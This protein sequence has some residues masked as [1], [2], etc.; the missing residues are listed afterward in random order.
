MLQ[1]RLAPSLAGAA[2][3]LAL[4]H[5]QALAATISVGGGCSLID[6][7]TA[8]NTDTATG[9][10]SAGSGADMISLPASSTHTLTSVNNSTYGDTGLPVVTSTI[11]IEGNDSTITRDSSAPAFRIFAIASTGDLTLQETTVSG[12]LTAG[13]GGFASGSGGGVY[14]RGALT[15]TDSTISGNTA[16]YG[17]GGVLNFLSTATLS[18]STISGNSAGGSGGGVYNRG[19]LTLTDSTISGNSAGN[20]G[21]GVYNYNSST[22]TLSNSTISGNTAFAGGGVSNGSSTVTVSDSTLSG[23]TA[24]FGGGVCNIYGTV[25]LSNSTISGNSAGSR[26]GGVYNFNSSTATLSNST[27]SGNSAG[28]G[29]GVFNTYGTVTLSNSTISGNSAGGGGG[30]FNDRYGTVTL[31]NSTISGNSA[32][33]GGGVFNGISTATLS[34]TL[35]AGNTA[36]VSGAEVQHIS[37]T[38]TADNFNLFGHDGL[39]NA[40][41]F[42]NFT[43]GA[44]DLT[45]T[46]DG[47]NPTA[48]TDILD[49]T[50]AANGGPTLTHALVTGSLAID[51]SPDD[52]DCQATDQRGVTRPQ[53]PACDIGAFEAGTPGDLAVL[54]VTSPKTVTLTS[55]KPVQSKTVKVQLQNQGEVD[56][57]IPD[58]ATLETLVQVDLESL[59][60]VNDCPDLAATLNASKLKFPLTLKVGKKL[61]LSFT[62]TFDRNECI[63]D[64]GKSSKKDPGHEDYRPMATVDLS[65]LGV[66]D[67]DPTDDTLEGKL[68]DVVN[69]P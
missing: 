62:V 60:T 11:T 33:Y 2:L 28:G 23:N 53:G 31:S 32:S 56:E 57:T 55:K 10:C 47:S 21:G 61:T 8:A 66:T 12:G 58:A 27:I 26:G 19:A 51:A 69:K 25:T 13:G 59:D 48:L 40:Q 63:P 49:T 17:G 6:A 22:A 46:S 29:G 42:S 52:A 24:S 64:P 34:R 45:A 35:I 36:A 65:A 4:G 39:T 41:A 3:L 43:P 20:R 30:V 68:I 37:G 7:I 15:L 9:G 14:N 38:I 50:L 44:T 1:R 54:K 5:G 16:S 18:N 67:V